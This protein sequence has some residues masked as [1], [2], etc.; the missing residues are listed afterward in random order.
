VSRRHLAGW[1]AAA[2][3]TLGVGLAAGCNGSGYSGSSSGG[4]YGRGGY[5]GNSG[6]YDP[7][8]YRPCCYGDDRPNNPQRPPGMR[9]PGSGRPPG[10][11]PPGGGRPPGIPSRPRPRPQRR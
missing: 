1:I 6:W 10:M 5:Y 2:L 7:G 11:R 9:P 3:L 8:Y 4:Y